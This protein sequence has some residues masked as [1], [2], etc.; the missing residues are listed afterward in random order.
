MIDEACT[1]P[2][3]FL[4][5][6]CG[7]EAVTACVYCGEPFCADHG[8][9]GPDYQDVCKRSACS[10][11]FEDLQ[12]HLAWRAQVSNANRVSICAEPECAERM[13]HACSQCR[14]LFCDLHIGEHDVKDT[15][16]MPARKMRTLVCAHCLA[17]RKIWE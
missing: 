15:R 2:L 7:R 9:R 1:Y 14:L 4:R 12:Q 5:R 8:I 3:G 13:R 6:G 11:K 17:R 16:V 10:A